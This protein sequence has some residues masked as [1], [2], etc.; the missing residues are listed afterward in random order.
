[1][2]SLELD[3]MK[4]KTWVDVDKF[5]FILSAPR[6]GSTLLRVLLN[7]IP[8][9]VSPPETYFLQFY[10]DNKKYNPLKASDRSILVDNWI[11]FRNHMNVRNLYDRKAFRELVVGEARSWKDIFSVLVQLYAKDANKRVTKNSIICEKTPI[12]IE[13]QKELLEVFSAAHIIYLI[14]DPRDVV[15]SLKTCPWARSDVKTN[16]YYWCKTANLIQECKNSILIKY[17]DL[18][19]NSSSE[20]KRIG[21]FLQIDID[22]QILHQEAPNEE[23]ESL[24][25]KNIASYKPIDSSFKDRWKTKLSE[26][27]YELEIIENICYA[28]MEKFGYVPFSGRNSKLNILIQLQKWTDKQYGRLYRRIL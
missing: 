3:K 10:R 1:M 25:D 18:I 2:D 19:E 20:F 4:T 14:R 13:F 16:S 23:K 17:E 24:D 28:D 12:H 27:D 26:P 7:R 22:D 9:V 21:R 15:A 5:I 11:N 6:S 8:D